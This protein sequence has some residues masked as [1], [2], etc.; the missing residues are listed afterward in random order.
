MKR[1]MCG[2]N[3]AALNLVKSQKNGRSNDNAVN[4]N[5]S[6]KS[7]GQSKTQLN[8][9]KITNKFKWYEIFMILIFPKT[10]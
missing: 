2:P 9:K 10:Y 5:W 8:N 1:K 7:D 3:L 6:K 4:Y